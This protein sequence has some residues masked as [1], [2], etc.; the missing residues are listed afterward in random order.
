MKHSARG[1]HWQPAEIRL[2]EN[3]AKRLLAG[4][5]VRLS[6][7]TQN[8]L[9]RLRDWYATRPEAPKS[10]RVYPRTISAVRNKIY[11]A[12]VL[13]GYR[14]SRL[15]WAPPER[16]LAYK[17]ARKFLRHRKDRPPLARLDA[18]RGLLVDLFTAGYDRTL[19]ACTMELDKCHAD[20]ARGAP[21][22][23]GRGSRAVSLPASVLRRKA[24]TRRSAAPRRASTSGASIAKQRPSRARQ[25]R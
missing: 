16:R 3:A 10:D 11:N 22:R 1:T 15:L 19:D 23:C 9:V 18:G 14:V 24:A 21:R 6:A 12:A 8:C 4:R 13:R 20:M 2:A 25:S 7:A 17:W 5:F